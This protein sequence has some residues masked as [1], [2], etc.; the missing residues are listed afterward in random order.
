MYASANLFIFEFQLF[1][2]WHRNGKGLR[3]K[4]QPPTFDRFTRLKD[5]KLRKS[6]FPLMFLCMCAF[7]RPFSSNHSNIF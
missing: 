5:R 6:G 1:D 2:L 3:Q 7:R 4:M